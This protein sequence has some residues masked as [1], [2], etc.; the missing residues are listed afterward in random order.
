MQVSWT[1]SYRCT[2]AG[3][4]EYI[5]QRH[6]FPL[7]IVKLTTYINRYWPA[8]LLA[9]R[10]DFT[11]LPP[12]TFSDPR[13]QPDSHLSRL[14]A[15]R[16][17]LTSTPSSLPEPLTAEEFTRLQQINFWS[18]N[19]HIYLGDRSR[20][21]VDSSPP[22]SITTSKGPSLNDLTQSITPEDLQALFYCYNRN[23]FRV[24]TR[25]HNPA[26]SLIPLAKE[27][28]SKCPNVGLMLNENYI[29]LQ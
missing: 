5:Q 22:S 26:P 23:L 1:L 24:P 14:R 20:W 28:S 8:L 29:H 7:A 17:Y 3:C 2:V 16:N 18:H 4:S 15:V 6:S 13:N 12:I 25:I 19:D 11:S 10:T 21:S 27:F 9:S